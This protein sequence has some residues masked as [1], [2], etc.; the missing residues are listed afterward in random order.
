MHL[1]RADRAQEPDDIRLRCELG[2]S[3]HDTRIGSL[4]VL[5]D[6]FDLLAEDTTGLVDGGERKLRAVLRPKPLLGRWTCHRHAHSDLG[7][8]GLGPGAA[9]NKWCCDTGGSQPGRKVASRQF[10]AILP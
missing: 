4:V 2:K 1:R 9:N 10:H 7:R 3:Q 8:R 5:D 6:Q